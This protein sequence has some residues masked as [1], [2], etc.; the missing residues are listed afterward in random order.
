MGSGIKSFR[1]NMA[2]SFSMIIILIAS[3]GW[4][5]DKV[6]VVTNYQRYEN[7][8]YEINRNTNQMILFQPGWQSSAD[9]G[10]IKFI[11]DQNGKDITK[12]ILGNLG[13]IQDTLLSPQENELIKSDSIVDVKTITII[14][15]TNKYNN[16][17]YQV[18]TT[19]KIIQIERDG[20]KSQIKFSDI[21][22]ILDK[23]GSDV[24]LLILGGNSSA[25]NNALMVAADSL[26][27]KNESH[28]N[29]KE[30]WISENSR[31]IEQ[32]RTKKWEAGIGGSVNFSVP[33]SSYYKGIHEG[34]GYEGTLHIAINH[35]MAVR[36]EIS[37]AGLKMGKEVQLYSNDPNISIIKQKITFTA[38]RYNIGVEFYKNIN[39]KVKDLNFWYTYSAVGSITHRSKTELTLRDN[40]TDLITPVSSIYSES[41]F[42]LVVG[43][44]MIKS[45]QKNWAI[46][47]S[48]SL[49]AVFLGKDPNRETT[50][51]GNNMVYAHIFD[52][53][54]GLIALF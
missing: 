6:T 50:F 3:N 40:Q 29:I 7:V 48:A 13:S 44:G 11:Y 31:T 34:I 18:D 14:T 28:G 2:I 9:L 25:E 20:W 35:E 17:I 24:T 52:F 16:V 23:N 12:D 22:T 21:D 5:S 47:L 43:I 4:A 19:N 36:I 39:R 30:S 1:L 10:S 41:K 33:A 8:T 49:D 54:A 46:D 37:R 32:A 38:M 15:N 51:F 26:K 42:N 53:K 27:I 45:I